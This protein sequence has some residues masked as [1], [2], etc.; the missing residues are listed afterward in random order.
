MS[1]MSGPSGSEEP[2]LHL[3][4]NQLPGNQSGLPRRGR[5]PASIQSQ[6]DE[7]ANDYEKYDTTTE[8]MMKYKMKYNKKNTMTIKEALAKYGRRRREADESARGRR[9]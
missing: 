4:G 9:S 7:A 5:G 8:N 2:E 6:E 3:P 1:G